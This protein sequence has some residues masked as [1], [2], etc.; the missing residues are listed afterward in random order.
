MKTNNF[1]FILQE[2]SAVGY[3]KYKLVMLALL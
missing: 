2:L 3:A 1:Q